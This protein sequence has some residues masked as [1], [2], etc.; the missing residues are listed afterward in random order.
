M[1]GLDFGKKKC[2]ICGFD[3][4][5]DSSYSVIDGECY[6]SVCAKEVMKNKQSKERKR[7]IITDSMGLSCYDTKKKKSYECVDDFKEVVD[8]L[9]KY[10][11]LVEELNWELTEI[12]QSEADNYNITDGLYD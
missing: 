12:K 1:F 10:D 6:C 4:E 2:H 8:L 9:N 11:V 3:V 7:Y 5:K